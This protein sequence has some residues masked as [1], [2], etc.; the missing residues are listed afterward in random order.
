MD[1]RG[2]LFYCFGIPELAEA[3]LS[4]SVA[5]SLAIASSFI[6]SNLI[7]KVRAYG[8]KFNARQRQS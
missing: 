1:E 3:A 4:G 2:K 6:L 5:S 8:K 7:K